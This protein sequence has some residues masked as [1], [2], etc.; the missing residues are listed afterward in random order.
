MRVDQAIFRNIRRH[1]ALKRP[2]GP[3]VSSW[4]SSL[5]LQFLVLSSLVMS[6][7]ALSA[8][9]AAE[10]QTVLRRAFAYAPDTNTLLYT[11]EHRETWQDGNIA[12]SEVR[13]LGPDK[14]LLAE[15]T[16]DFRKNRLAPD[17]LLKDLRDGY[18]EG[19][20]LDGKHVRVTARRN[21]DQPV[22]TRALKVPA[23]VVIDGGFNEFVM[24][25]WNE[26]LAGKTLQFQFV[27]PIEQDYFAFQVTPK[28]VRQRDGGG[29][30][31]LE[32]E[33][34]SSLVRL[35]V[36]TVQLTYDVADRHLLQFEGMT[37]LNDA[38]G[39]STIARLVYP[40]EEVKT[41]TAKPVDDRQV[42]LVAY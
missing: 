24:A 18:Q 8:P 31:R 6:S 30:L 39:K 22:K 16:M 9:V 37:N 33:P 23:P 14:Q 40:K 38:K 29:Q 34:V 21:A 41:L 3:S 11:E 32:M 26:L 10:E 28:K 25:H 7:L 2:V 36:G 1:T 4:L 27:A 17:F 12:R 19:A 35:F 13:Y 5:V 20:S 15:K 42:S